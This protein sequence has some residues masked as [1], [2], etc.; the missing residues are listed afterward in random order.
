MSESSSESQ[1]SRGIQTPLKSRCI[2]SMPSFY[3][4]QQESRNACLWI[5]D[6][7]RYGRIKGLEKKRAFVIGRDGC[8]LLANRKGYEQFPCGKFRKCSERF[9]TFRNDSE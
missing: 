6:A 2:R 3:L 1:I 5:C 8:G 4:A 9:R 7:S